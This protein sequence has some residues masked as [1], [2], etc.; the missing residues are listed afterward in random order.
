M[1]Y[2]L[3]SFFTSGNEELFAKLLADTMTA[4]RE[5]AMS[6]FQLQKETEEQIKDGFL[7]RK[8]RDHLK[9]KE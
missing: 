2:S 8:F 5:M 3:L 1:Y 9:V 6:Y 4:K 7:Q